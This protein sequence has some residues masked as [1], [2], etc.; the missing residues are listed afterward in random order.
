MA[1]D[2]DDEELEMTRVFIH[3]LPPKDVKNGD[4]VDKFKILSSNKINKEVKNEI[5]ASN[6]FIFNLL[7]YFIA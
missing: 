3:H 7:V 5:F 6:L 1:F 4:N 2:L